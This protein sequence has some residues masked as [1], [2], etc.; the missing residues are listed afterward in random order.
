MSLWERIFAAAYDPFMA[1]SE[2]TGLARHRQALLATASGRVLE[3]GGGTGAN[4]PFYGDGVTEV[5]ITEPSAPMAGRLARKLA[6]RTLRAPV[7]LVQAPAERLP[8][9]AASFDC[10]VTTLV[11]CTVADLARSLAE[12]RRVLKPR[13]RLLFIEHV[14]S[15]HPPL[16]RWQDRL[17]VP[18]AWFG[19]GCQCNRATVEAVLAAGFKIVELRRDML[20]KAPPVVKSIVVGAA[21]SAE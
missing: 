5:V 18:W 2:E 6:R 17:R 7:R 19:C 14:R 15:D 9:E 4:L 13:G 20:P 16:A 3:V 10:A 8:F 1:A 11:L 12:V 21:I